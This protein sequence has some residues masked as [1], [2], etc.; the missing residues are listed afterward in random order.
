MGRCTLLLEV[1][2]QMWPRHPERLWLQRVPNPEGGGR[3][4]EE[5]SE[6]WG[7]T[8]WERCLPSGSWGSGVHFGLQ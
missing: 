4:G 8:R 6:R 1:C 2:S 5:G 3:G 7:R